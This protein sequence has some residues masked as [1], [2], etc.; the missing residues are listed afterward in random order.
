MVSDN[1]VVQYLFLSWTRKTEIVD[2]VIINSVIWAE[3]MGK[4]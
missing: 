3:G 1:G 2:V 4:G